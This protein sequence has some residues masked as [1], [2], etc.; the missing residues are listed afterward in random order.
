MN[1][2]NILL[3]FLIFP[4]IVIADVFDKMDK[5]TAV[6]TGIN[7]L[8]LEERTALLAWLT[9]SDNLTEEV[10]KIQKKQIKEIKQ[11]VRSEIIAENKQKEVAKEEIIRQDKVK[12]MGFTQKITGGREEIHSSIVNITTSNNG[13]KVYTLENGQRWK[14]IETSKLFIPGNKTN[15]A[16]TIK[17][18][19]L[20][21]WS[22]SVDGFSRNVKVKRIK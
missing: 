18:K 1:K 2:L 16:V 5:E 20:G 17:P 21:S 22:L 9:S 13:K 8:S 12:N 6:T 3:L 4:V 7:K 14:Q 19:S 15:P 11:Q 10:S